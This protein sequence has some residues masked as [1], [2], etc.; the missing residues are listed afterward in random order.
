MPDIVVP[1]QRLGDASDASA[2]QGTYVLHGKIYAARVGT[3]KKNTEAQPS[4]EVV[5][6]KDGSVVPEIGSV[7]TAKVTKVNPRL[8][9]LQILC[10][11]DRVVRQSFD[12]SIRSQDVRSTQIDSV[13]M[14]K[15]FRPGDVVRAEVISLGDA[16]SY[17]LSTAGSPEFGVIFAKSLAGETLAPVSAT[18]MLDPINQTVEYRKVAKIQGT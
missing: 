10:V 15:S 6:E 11:G 14:Y 1:G 16:R 17:F 9:S 18:E 2:G 3:L 13:E 8:A 5:R 7:V 4:L 12:A